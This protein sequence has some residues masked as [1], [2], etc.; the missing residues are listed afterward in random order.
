MA[1]SAEWCLKA[2]PIG[3][4]SSGPLVVVHYIR[5][6]VA[7]WFQ[8]ISNFGILEFLKI[9]DGNHSLGRLTLLVES[10]Y[11]V[12]LNWYGQYKSIANPFEAHLSRFRSVGDLI[13]SLGADLEHTLNARNLLDLMVH[14]CGYF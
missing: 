6:E 2:T 12:L 7:I 4:T 13:Q 3:T 1:F 8:V 9:R 10:R 11:W 14:P 5:L